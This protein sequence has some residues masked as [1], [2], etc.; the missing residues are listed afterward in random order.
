[1]Q[2]IYMFWQQA[3]TA[4][5]HGRLHKFALKTSVMLKIRET[6]D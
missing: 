5:A 4:N 2:I 6:E 1:M 3:G